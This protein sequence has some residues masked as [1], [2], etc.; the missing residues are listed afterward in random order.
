M[1]RF[2][3][4]NET[5]VKPERLQ[6]QLIFLFRGDIMTRINQVADKFGLEDRRGTGKFSS[7][8]LQIF[9]LLLSGLIVFGLFTVYPIIKLFIISFFDWKIGLGQISQFIWFGNYVNV[10]KDPVF[11]TAIANTFMYALITVPGQIVLGLLTAVLITGISRFRVGF[12]VL[13][14]L[15]VITSWV[16][17][18]LVFR[19]IFNNEGFLNYFI[20]DVVH[21]VND[22]INWLDERS[23][24]MFVAELLGIWKGIGW[25]M[26][27]FLAALQAVPVELYEVADIDGCNRIKKFFF[28]TLPSIKNTILF[29]V[30]MLSIGAF[31]VFTSIQ[32]MTGGEPAH[33]TEVLLTW[34][35][36]KAFEARDFGYSA[37][38]S[39]IMALAIALITILQFKAFK[40]YKD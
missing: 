40:K 3:W 15:P 38:L 27:I 28:I 1:F 31:N 7:K 39:Y 9:L 6:N 5:P 34:M 16:I 12:R 35:Y 18:S 36:Y 8:G 25:N 20:K 29:T 24:G 26:V 13:Y 4:K 19:Y 32:L 10:F 14:Y 17:V 21:I 22:N 33:Q 11:G 2:D 30:V 23:T 37:A